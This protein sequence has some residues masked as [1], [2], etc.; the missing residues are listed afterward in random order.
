MKPNVSIIVPVYN[1]ELYIEK[2]LDS[3]VNQKYDNLEVIVIDDGSTDN[4]NA[5]CRQYTYKYP[6]INLFRTDNQ[7]VS[8]AR[9]LGLNL[10]QADYISF[11]DSDD[12]IEEMY[13]EEMMSEINSAD[14]V[15]AGINIEANTGNQI[16]LNNLRKGAYFLEEERRLLYGR[17]LYYESPYR[18]G[19][20]PYMCNKIYKKEILLPIFE[21][22]D[23]RIWDGEDVAVIYEYLL[24]SKR[25]IVTDSCGYHYCIRN[26][27]ASFKVHPNAFMNATILYQYLYNSFRKYDEFNILK[28]QIDQY[29][30]F[31]L[32]KSD[33]DAYIMIAGSKFVFPYHK[34]K[35]N[36]R[37]VIYGAGK[38]GTSFYRQISA[39]G[40][41]QI[42]GWIDKSPK[43]YINGDINITQYPPTMI[44]ELEFDYIVIA[45]YD[46]EACRSVVDYIRH[47]GVANEKI[48]E[49]DYKKK[50]I[51]E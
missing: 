22:L 17:M 43:Q 19:I 37:I 11:V 36:S 10:A 8:N 9:L 30:R 42:V 26:D 47:L 2:C 25:I 40:K 14:I 41:Y 29:L 50:R 13:Y 28:P 39:T 32:W 1:S 16:E 35:E 5:I 7:G 4:S 21:R 46:E 48:I 49:T 24:L 6:Y 51:T 18:F 23:K 3:I 44:P 33:P 27:S 20:L 31:M 12:W 15:L 34:V 45:I 38:M